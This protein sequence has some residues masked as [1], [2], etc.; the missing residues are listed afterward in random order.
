MCDWGID[1]N[2]YS[3]EHW[4]CCFTAN[5][6]NGGIQIWRHWMIYSK[7]VVLGLPTILL[8]HGQHTKY[9]MYNKWD[10]LFGLE[11]KQLQLS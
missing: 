7:K 3:E 2:V 1:Y 8:A 5:S 4:T 11:I 10:I 9:N 6:V